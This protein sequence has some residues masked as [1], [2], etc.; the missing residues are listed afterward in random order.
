MK[1]PLIFRVFK[2]NQIHFVKQF[3]DKDQIVF[4]SSLDSGA[5]VDVDL[6]SKEVSA[7]H[8]L[9]EK[10]GTQYHLCDLGSSQGTYKNGQVVLDEPINT[11]DEFQVGPFKVVFF[12]G[13]PKPV[14][15]QETSSEIVVAA[16][17]KPTEAPAKT[18][19]VVTPPPQAPPVVTAP[20]APAAQAKPTINAAFV[21]QRAVKN[22][23]FAKSKK[24]KNKKTFAPASEHQHINEFIKPGHGSSVDVIVSWK[25][26]VLSTHHF[27]ARGQYKAGPEQVIQLPA[28]ATPK[29][30]VMLDCTNGVTVRLSSDMKAEVHRAENIMVLS[31]SNY[32][33]QQN[34][35]LFITLANGMHLAI[36][37]APKTKLIPLD[38]PL[39]LTSS[40]FTGI[41]AALIFAVLLSLIMSV[42]A[43]KD[44]D[45]EEEVQRVAQ[46][47]FNKPPVPVNPP[48]VVTPPPT[49]PKEVPP[50]KPPEPPKKVAITDK[51]QEVKSKGNPNKVEQKAQA[52]QSS[53]RANEVK[54]KDPKN[55]TKMFTSTKQGGAVKT[56]NKAGANAQSKE[57]DPTNSGLLSA[58]GSGGARSKLDKAYSGSGE[59]LGAGEK[60]TG[61]SGFNENR[62]GDDLGSKFK[63]T[64]AGGKGTATQGIAGV[65]TKGGNGYGTGS[66]GSGFG[67]KDSVAIQAGGA[68]E[69]FIGS[70]DKEAVR[71]VVRSALQAFKACYDR[72]YKKDTKLEGK[73]V[74]SWEIHEKGVAKNA[75]VVKEKSTLDN[76]AVGE[77]VRARLMTLRF[78]EPPA[79]SMAEAVYP[80]L[81]QGQ[82]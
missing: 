26:R 42:L 14:H 4:G 82:R 35:V 48:V 66:V 32:K 63:D 10:R 40:E 39:I 78:P 37:F 34:E 61:A 68:E 11:N 80:F 43:P 28:G 57:K 67:N 17:S 46:V 56:G 65:G 41:L 55:K 29:D 7:I 79:G 75:R 38:S 77:C 31:E 64:G 3:I 21:G 62:A 54:P 20:P 8:C 69:E 58:F 52:S 36:R 47:I 49:P 13:V 53:G 23:S 25:E 27:E 19:A 24:G 81:F 22:Q 18:T 33:L 44:S 73:V 50:P 45:K 59:A 70:I 76:P 12:V 5:E 15:N 2:N 72:E 60:A 1:S 71:R 30:W 16:N 74:I 51:A 6:E 9:V